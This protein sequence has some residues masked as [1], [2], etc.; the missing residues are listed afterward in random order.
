[1]PAKSVKQRDFF[2]VV[3]Q[4]KTHKK[5]RSEVN[6]EIL[7][8]VDGEMSL[9]DI[10][11]MAN[12]TNKEIADEIKKMDENKIEGG[13]GDDTKPKDVD[14]KELKVGIEVEMEHTTNREIAEEIA[15][16]HLSEVSDYYTKLIK[17]GLVDEKP[18]LDKYK[19]LFDDDPSKYIKETA[20]QLNP[21]NINGM[22]EVALPESPLNMTEFGKQHTGSGDTP[23]PKKRKKKKT[24]EEKKKMLY[25]KSY[26]KFS[27]NKSR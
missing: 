2:Q 14:S 21:K 5:K 23:Y 1:M 15:I 12:T 4:V 7:D 19:E 18:A 6:K 17:S 10:K 22:G 26:D 8:I 11:D 24:E 9:A 20:N 16:D 25:I 13:N 3:L 27:G